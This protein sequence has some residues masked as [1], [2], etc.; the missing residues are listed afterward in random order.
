MGRHPQ[1]RGFSSSE[2]DLAQPNDPVRGS[3]EDQ[4]TLTIPPINLP[5]QQSN[6]PGTI[7]LQPAP[8]TPAMPDPTP[9]ARAGA[10]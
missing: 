5:G 1:T 4:M 7:I 10:V 9:P 2:A 3:A 8:A 6:N